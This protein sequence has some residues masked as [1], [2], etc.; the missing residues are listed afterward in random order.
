MIR[1]WALC[2][3]NRGAGFLLTFMIFVVCVVEVVSAIKFSSAIEVT[4]T[5]YKAFR[6][7][8]VTSPGPAAYIALYC[9]SA[10]DTVILV[11]MGLSA[12]RVRSPGERV[13]SG[14][15]ISSIAHQDGI[16]FYVCILCLTLTSAT[17]IRLAPTTLINTAYPLPIVVYSVLS[18]RVILNIRLMAGPDNGG[19]VATELHMASRRHSTH[20]PLTFRN[21]DVSRNSISRSDGL[22]SNPSR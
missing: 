17:V 22:E 6:G 19:S 14:H 5:P 3:R 12:Y 16:L 4:S 21:S 7:C 13:R 18:T 10:L 11:L 20:M 2:Y 15:T 1:T 9:L 8:V